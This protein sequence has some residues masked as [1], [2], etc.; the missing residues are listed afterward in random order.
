MKKMEAIAYLKKEVD[1]RKSE[2]DDNR[3]LE[4][5]KYFLNLARDYG[6]LFGHTSA[7]GVLGGLAPKDM[8]LE[9]I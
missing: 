1:T 9:V 8:S 6:N 2:F 7:I 3:V 5:G 4:A